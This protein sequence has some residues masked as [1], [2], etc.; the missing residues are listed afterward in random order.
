M[1][2][3]ILVKV[4][5][6]NASKDVSQKFMEENHI[7]DSISELCSLLE[8]KTI[9][10]PVS[11]LHL[12]CTRVIFHHGSVTGSPNKPTHVMYYLVSTLRKLFEKNLASL[13][14][15]IF[16]YQQ[17]KTLRSRTTKK[18]AKKGAAIRALN[19]NA[20]EKVNVMYGN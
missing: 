20:I 10:D 12:I 17:S 16:I 7:T 2:K 3:N 5:K 14:P 9:T 8:E 19:S 15:Y 4:T 1:E 6:Q 13:N 11:E 18:A